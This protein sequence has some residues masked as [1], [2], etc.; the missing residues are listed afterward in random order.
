MSGSVVSETG[1][2]CRLIVR[3]TPKSARDSVAG[4]VE[5]A[6]GPALAVRVRAAPESGKANAAVC[7]AV[8]KWL[9]IAKSRVALTGGATSRVKTLAVDCERTAIEAA[10]DQLGGARD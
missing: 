4:I 10:L 9:G 3:A 8:A 2:G 7:A 6:N 1:D 5:T